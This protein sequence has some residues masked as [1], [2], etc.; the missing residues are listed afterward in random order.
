MERKKERNKRSKEIKEGNEMGGGMKD[1]KR[2]RNRR[3]K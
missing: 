2:R 1:E 3:S